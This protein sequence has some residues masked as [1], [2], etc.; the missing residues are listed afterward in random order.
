MSL[1]TYIPIVFYFGGSSCHQSII[2]Q[3]LVIQIIYFHIGPIKLH[4]TSNGA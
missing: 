4:K 2:L 1:N 3:M